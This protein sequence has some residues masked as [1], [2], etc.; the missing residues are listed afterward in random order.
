MMPQT[1]VDDGLI[2]ESFLHADGHRSPQRRWGSET[3]QDVVVMLHGG[4]SHSGWQAPLGGQL[5]RSSDVTLIAP[6]RRGAGEDVDGRGDMAS[7]DQVLDDVTGLVAGLRSRFDRVHLGGWCFGAQVA[8]VA[9][10][11][12]LDAGSRPDS[13]LLVAPG[14]YWNKRYSDVLRLSIA[15][16]LNAVEEL[17]LHP[18]ESRAF[19]PLPL[20]PDDFTQ[21]PEWRR[22]IESDPLRL[23]KV[24]K[25]TVSISYALQGQALSVLGGLRGVPVL[26]VLAARDKLVDNERGSALLTNGIRDPRARIEELDANHA[27]QFDRP[28]ELARLVLEFVRAVAQP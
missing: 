15:S 5:V 26:A 18:S 22:F 25:N 10:A 2:L 3:G 21:D 4:M 11:R 7:I 20:Q 9:T 19:I 28:R 8:A 1:A 6:D 23:T 24:S 13:L 27:I 12:L 16:V 14:L 17:G